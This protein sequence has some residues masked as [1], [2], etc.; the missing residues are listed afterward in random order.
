M[1]TKISQRDNGRHVNTVTADSPYQINPPP[2]NR[3]STQHL[4][5]SNN[6]LGLELSTDPSTA[7]GVVRTPSSTYQGGMSYHAATTHPSRYIHALASDT[8]LAGQ[9]NSMTAPSAHSPTISNRMDLSPHQSPTYPLR[10]VRPVPLSRA[11][12]VASPAGT[13]A[14]V[15]LSSAPLRQLEGPPPSSSSPRVIAPLPV[16]TKKRTGQRGRT[17]KRQRQQKSS[18]EG[19]DEDGECPHPQESRIR[20]SM[21]LIASHTNPINIHAPTQS[22]ALLRPVLSNNLALV[23]PGYNNDDPPP[24]RPLQNSGS[25]DSDTSDHGRPMSTGDDEV[26]ESLYEEPRRG[27]VADLRE[28]CELVNKLLEDQA[29]LSRSIK[30]IDTRTQQMNTNPRN[31]SN[32]LSGSGTYV[33]PPEP[34]LPVNWDQTIQ[35]D[36][37]AGRK[38]RAKRHVLLMA[39]IRE[40]IFRLLSRHSVHD[41]LPPPPPPALRAPTIQNFAIRWEES[42]KSIFNELAARVVAEK[43]A[44]EQPGM[45]TPDEVE[46]LPALVSKHIKYLCRCYKDQNREDAEDFNTRRL[47]RCLQLVYRFWTCFLSTSG[48]I[49]I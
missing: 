30:Q 12:S 4:R 16:Q 13:L 44:C 31:R 48:S 27:N 39:L 8:F 49:V 3:Q 23:A 35:F 18:S 42:S 43:I 29:E 1:N 25:G 22:L 28:L 7:H 10:S 14:I 36:A 46:E 37:P 33:S 11:P 32:G 45:L 21:L 20:P 6:F 41:P 24:A 15:P 26:V 9:S 19:S 17:R 34:T 47:N 2:G 38:R 40:T 5:V